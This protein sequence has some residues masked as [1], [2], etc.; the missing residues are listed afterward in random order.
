VHI[1][2]V[3]DNMYLDRGGPVAVV[4]GLSRAQVEMGDRVS[5]LCRGR[6]RLG[7][8]RS[9]SHEL[10][11]GVSLIETGGS[12]HPDASAVVASIAP[13]VLH[14][15]G[16]WERY[17]GWIS[18]EARIRD[19]PWVVSTHG[20]MHPV[21]MAKGWLKKRAFLMLFGAAIR[22]SRRL[23]V[24]SAE[25]RKFATRITG[26]AA[27]VLFNGVDLDEVRVVARDGAADSL[28]SIR[29]RPYILFL[30]R[31]HQ[32]K[33][34]DGLIRSFAIA[35][36]RGLDADLV[37]AGP[38]DGFE[39]IASRLAQELGVADWVHQVGALYGQD[40]FNALSGCRLMVHR[41]R[42]EGFGM[43]IV[44]AM[45]AGR[46]VLTTAAS[47]V[48]RQCPPGTLAICEDS[49]EGFAA[50]ITLLCSPDQAARTE[51]MAARGRDWVHRELTWEVIARRVRD[52]YR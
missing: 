34:I 16:V 33:G 41:P 25:E 52:L 17:L 28:A 26:V 42:Y 47:G 45:A 27:E 12:S 50:G 15:H 8:R 13:D 37:L 30:G 35:R 31:I 7:E 5:V 39:G 24:T 38:P 21:P 51:S 1:V 40:K 36:S 49:D 3:I 2:H 43:T 29:S 23:L 46:P 10:P 19:I 6:L 9:R 20:M 44:E 14:L 4:E 11:V 48:A 32:L 18:A 22:H